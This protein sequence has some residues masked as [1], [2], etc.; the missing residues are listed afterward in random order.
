[1]CGIIC[2]VGKKKAKPSLL[3][4]LKR[5]EYRGYDSA[6]L[7]IQVGDQIDYRRAVGKI[8]ELEIQADGFVT[9]VAGDDSDL[10]LAGQCRDQNA[11]RRDHEYRVVFHCIL[12]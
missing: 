11:Q 8:L 1:M 9:V 7:A 5:L 6:G 10:G 2:Y 3:E 4:G 12:L